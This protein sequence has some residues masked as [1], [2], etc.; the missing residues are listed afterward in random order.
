MP[1]G[2]IE[3]KARSLLTFPYGVKNDTQK[4]EQEN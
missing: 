3:T 4:K 1:I 2:Y